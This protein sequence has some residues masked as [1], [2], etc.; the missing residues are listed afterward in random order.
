[1]ER[2]PAPPHGHEC[3][4]YEGR[5]IN[6]ASRSRE[7]GAMVSLRYPLAGRPLPIT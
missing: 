6:P 5:G 1:M 7:V 3:P 2:G 4:C